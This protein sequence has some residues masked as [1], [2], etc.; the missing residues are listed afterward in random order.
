[1]V[2]G[3]VRADSERPR[4]DL[5]ARLKGVRGGEPVRPHPLLLQ[6]GPLQVG[7]DAPPE[8]AVD[9]QGDGDRAFV[10]VVDRPA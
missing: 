10:V 4:L 1:V 9:V 2:A 6:V 3:A 7:G 8:S 5:L